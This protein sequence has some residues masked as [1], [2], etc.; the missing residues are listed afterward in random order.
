MKENEVRSRILHSNIS[1]IAL[2]EEKLQA[3]FLASQKIIQIADIGILLKEILNLA[4]DII[5]AERGIAI[6]IDEVGD[7]YRTVASEVLEEKEITF[8]RSVVQKTIKSGEVLLSLDVK[9]DERFKDSDSIKGLNVL[10]FV[11]VPLIAPASANPIGTLYVDQR[12]HKKIFTND[13]IAF[14][15]AF[16][17]LAAIAIVNTNS[18]DQLRSEKVQLLEEIGKKYSFPGI[19][20]QA[21][22]MQRVF[23]TIKRIIN[24]NCT[25]LITGESGTGKEVIAK[26]MHYNSMRRDKPFIAINCGALPETL[27]ETELFGSVRGAYTD[28]IDKTGLLQAAQGGTVFLD[29]IHH[30]SEAMQVKL[31]RF[32]QDKETRRIGGTKSIKVDVRL[33]CA[34]NENLQKEIA[35]GR[36]RKDFY[37]RINVVTINV[38]PLREHKK[39]IPLLAEHFLQK[40]CKEKNR[41]CLGFDA[42]V[43]K[44]LCDYDW[45]ENNVRELENEIERA[46]IF[47]KDGS[48]IR[49][50]E[51]S[52]K[53]RKFA[54][55]PKDISD[56]FTDKLGRSLDYQG[57]EKRYIKFILTQAGGNKAKA[58]KLMGIPRTTLVSKMKKLG[59]IEPVK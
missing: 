50:K 21:H 44:A 54:R 36:F 23:S 1:H 35:D 33:I 3:L 48:R 24:D 22:A 39:D 20:G 5:G 26:A 31:L 10:S 59:L 27:L 12:L 7:V 6:L 30:T 43:L 18:T 53:V 51:L 9:N 25:V 55:P 42:R 19:V 16:A 38:P 41:K 32:L 58:A 57:Y 4:I 40:Y 45:N 11:C 8:S 15:T 2:P 49:I 37:Y 29:E 47:A 17:N 46:I 56:L 14:L 13:D 28:A 52:E 34:S